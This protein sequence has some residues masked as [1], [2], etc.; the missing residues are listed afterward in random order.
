MNAD[1]ETKINVYH[2]ELV[3]ELARLQFMILKQIDT[4]C[5]KSDTNRTELLDQWNFVNAKMNCYL[6]FT[7]DD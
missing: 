4:S 3:S 7:S 2:Y 1:S 5:S 6:I